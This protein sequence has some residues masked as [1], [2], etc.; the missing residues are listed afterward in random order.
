MSPW[1]VV[2]KEPSLSN[3]TSPFECKRPRILILY[4]WVETR[5]SLRGASAEEKAYWFRRLASTSVL[6][7]IFAEWI[8]RVKELGSS[9][10]GKLFGC[11][12]TNSPSSWKMCTD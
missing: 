9:K 7:D 8:A 12:G 2:D 6:T 10:I 1:G 5:I 11:V 3:G 4:P